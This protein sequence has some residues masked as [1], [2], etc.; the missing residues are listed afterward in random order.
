M[1]LTPTGG[2]FGAPTPLLVG[3]YGR[4]RAAAAAPDGSL[5]I[6]TSNRDGRGN[7]KPDDDQIIRIVVSGAG[8]ADRS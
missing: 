8:G 7:P 5:W 6:S 2:L 3:A 1:Q 4:L